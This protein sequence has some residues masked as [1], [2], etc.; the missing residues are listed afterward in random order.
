GDEV[1]QVGG[2]E[3]DESEAEA[4]ALTDDGEHGLFCDYGDASAHLHI[5]DDGGRAKHNG[6]EETVA[7]QRACLGGEDDLPQIN[8]AAQ[9]GHNSQG[10][11]EEL[12]H[13]P[14]LSCSRE[15]RSWASWSFLMATAGV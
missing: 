2:D 13:K 6:P 10:D 15:W 9:G 3:S 12:F 14:A 11:A 5:N 7:K 1:E 4:E 8:K